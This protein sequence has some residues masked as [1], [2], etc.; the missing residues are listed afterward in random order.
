M[1]NLPES[2]NWEDGI[3]QFRENRSDDG[4]RGQDHQPSSHPARQPYSVFERPA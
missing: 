1:A 4:Q 3:Y 2:S